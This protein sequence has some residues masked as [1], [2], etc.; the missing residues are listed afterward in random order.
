MP[1][2]PKLKYF[3]QPGIS[4]RDPNFYDESPQ[5]P[6]APGTYD[7]NYGQDENLPAPEST[8]DGVPFKVK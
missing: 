4:H 3:N 1:A 6:G 8:K 2:P 5:I 7:D